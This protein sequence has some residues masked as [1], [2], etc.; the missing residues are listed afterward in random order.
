MNR[1]PWR[2]PDKWWEP[3]LK[4]WR[5]WLLKPLRRLYARIVEQIDHFEIQRA[6]VV[7]ELLEQDFGVLITPNHA[8]HADSSAICAAAE[9]IGRPVYFMTAWQVFAMAGRLEQLIY[10]WHGCFSV[11]R[12]G[13][14]RQAFRQ[15]GELLATSPFPLVIFPEGEVYHLN[16]RVC[17]FYDGPAAI[18]TSAARKGRPIYCVP[19]GIRYV[20]VSDPLPELHEV[21]NRLE[22]RIGWRP[23]PERPLMER[24]YRFAGAALALKEIE[25]MGRPQEGSLAQRVQRLAE[26]VLRGLE[27]EHGVESNSAPIPARVKTLRRIII[28]QLG[29]VEPARATSAKLHRQLDDLHFVVQLYSYPGDYLQE[30]PTLERLAETIDKFEEDA[31]GVASATP[32]GRRA[33]V[34]RFGEPIRIK[35]ERTRSRESTAQLTRLL[36]RRVQE[37]LDELSELQTPLPPAAIGNGSPIY[38]VGSR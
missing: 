1:Q 12:E 37:L 3:R 9:E 34:V 10:Q 18:A 38:H 11:D 25:Y 13:I 28:R 26:F 33:V 27:R 6:E 5:W 36:E 16:D 24:L 35:G 14:D 4:A 15:A 23:T 30:R 22:E 32:R 17:P 2:V 8:G 29:H 20:Y 21:M 19:C 31:L 7:R